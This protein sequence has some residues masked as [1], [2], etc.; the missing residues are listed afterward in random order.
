MGAWLCENYC[1]CLLGYRAQ[2]LRTGGGGALT[3]RSIPLSALMKTND[4]LIY[5]EIKYKG[6]W[7]WVHAA[8]ELGLLRYNGVQT[9]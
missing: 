4:T 7:G 8:G 3:E 2:E 6:G 9:S 1:F 5:K